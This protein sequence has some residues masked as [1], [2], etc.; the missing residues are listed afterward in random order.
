MTRGIPRHHARFDEYRESFSHEPWPIS[1]R[2]KVPV[3]FASAFASRLLAGYPIC[4]AV[5]SPHSI[6][7]ESG[8]DPRDLQMVHIQLAGETVITQH[9]RSTVLRPGDVSVYNFGSPFLTENQ[10]TEVLIIGVP[11]QNFGIPASR[12]HGLSGIALERDRPLVQIL[13][14][15]ARQ[16]TR[17]LNSV[18]DA[19]GNRVVLGMIGVLSA[20]LVETTCETDAGPRDTRLASILQYIESNLHRP[21]LTVTEIAAANFVSPRTLHALFETHETTAAAWIRS[22]RLENCKRDLTDSAFAELTIAE[23]AAR[24]GLRDAALFSRQFAHRFGI[25]PRAYRSG[26]AGR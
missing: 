23:I 19:V 25:T 24:W 12:L 18:D 3:T 17:S 6:E 11:A 2:S 10:G 22:R 26:R 4:T 20:A 13:H 15:F 5:S 7:H 9:D 16:L 8:T 14:P 21:G 1:V